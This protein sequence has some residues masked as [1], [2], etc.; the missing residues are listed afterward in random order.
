LKGTFN[1]RKS[2]ACRA[3]RY[4]NTNWIEHLENPAKNYP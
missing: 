4:R 2:R 3:N 1:S